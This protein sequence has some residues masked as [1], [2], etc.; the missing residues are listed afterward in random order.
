[1]KIKELTKKLDEYAQTKSLA[2]AAEICDELLE[3]MGDAARWING[4]PTTEEPCK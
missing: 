1:M 4:E 2:L 3:D